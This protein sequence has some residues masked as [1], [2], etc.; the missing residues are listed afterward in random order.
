M[1]I[2]PG[3]DARRY[4]RSEA[5]NRVG[6]HPETL[7][8]Y[9]RIGLMPAP[10]RLKGGRRA[11]DSEA[12]ER[13]AFI[14]SARALQFPIEEIGTLLRLADLGEDRDHEACVEAERVLH[15]HLAA[16]RARLAELRE[17][18]RTLARLSER[19]R[20]HPDGACPLIDALKSM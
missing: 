5:A 2:A 16:V 17:I 10:A 8:Y 11:Y 1:P 20:D 6:C 13:L 19:F 7:R 9:E 4:S 3:G 15:T 18:E 12:V 14:L